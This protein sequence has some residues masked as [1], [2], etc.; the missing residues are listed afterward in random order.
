M[1]PPRLRSMSCQVP[2]PGDGPSTYSS[3]PAPE[4]PS[5]S[6]DDTPSGDDARTR[7]PASAVTAIG[8]AGMR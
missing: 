3:Q 2:V 8:S 4:V 1:A 6:Y 5:S 7:S